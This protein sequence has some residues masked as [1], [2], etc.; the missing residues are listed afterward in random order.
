MN[1][2]AGIIRQTG[3]ACFVG[4]VLF[5]MGI[6]GCQ[7]A[8]NSSQQ[9]PLINTSQTTTPTGSVTTITVPTTQPNQTAAIVTGVISGLK[10]VVN[11]I[12]PQYEPITDTTANIVNIGVLGLI[13]GLALLFAHKTTNTAITTPGTTLPPTPKT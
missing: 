8:A 7:Q 2:K 12:A 10:T 11:T 4:A 9:T 6:G 3:L 5:A 13:S 1:V